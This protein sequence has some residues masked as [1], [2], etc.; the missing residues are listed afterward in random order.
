LS[1]RKVKRKVR[2]PT[3]ILNVTAKLVRPLMSAFRGK[4][5]IGPN[6]P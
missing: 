6:W 3:L 5:D 1:Q 4:A 2:L